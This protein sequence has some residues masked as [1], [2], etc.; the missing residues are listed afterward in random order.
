MSPHG[1][2]ILRHIPSAAAQTTVRRFELELEFAKSF[3][4]AVPHPPEWDR[5]IARAESAYASF[6]PAGGVAALETLLAEMESGLAELGK[7]AKGYT[8]HC[9][10]HGHID[11]NWMWSWPETVATTHDT[12]A[13]VLQ[14]MDLYPEFTYSQ[15]QGSVYALTERYHPQQ[16]EEIGRRVAEGRWEVAAVHWVEGDKNLASGESIARHLLYSRR[17]FEEKFGLGPEAIRIDWEPDTFGHANTIPNI[18]AQAGVA[19]YYCCRPGGGHNHHRV[20]EPRPPV[21]WWQGTDGSRVLVNRETTWYNSYVNIG[22]NIAVP[23]CP[24]VKETGLHHWLNVYGVGNHGGGPTR[25]EI[26]WYRELATWPIYPTVAFSTA[27]RCFDAMAKEIEERRLPIPVLDHELNFEFTG[28]YT[29]QSAIKKANRCGENLCVEAESLE[30]VAVAL[31]APRS[32]EG[33]VREAWINV[34]FNQFH[35]ILPGSG[36]TQTREHATGIFQE[37]AAITG[38]IKRNAVRFIERGIDT[39]SLIPDTIDGSAER[40][41]M[42]ESALPI[43]YGAGAGDGSGVTGLGKPG[44]GGRRFVPFVI[45]NPTPHPRSEIVDLSLFDHPFDAAQLVARDDTGRQVAVLSGPSEHYWGHTKTPVVVPVLDIPPLGYRTIVVME[46]EPNAELPRILGLERDGFETPDL[47]F[48]MDRFTSGVASWHDKRTGQ[49]G[50]GLGSWRFVTERPQGMT[51]WVLGAVQSDVPLESRSFHVHGLWRNQGTDAPMGRGECF[52]V[53]QHCV[54]PGTESTVTLTTLLHALEPRIDVE[55]TV[56]WR[57]IG[58]NERGIPGLV[59]D[60]GPFDAH[61]VVSETP[62]GVVER[63]VDLP[64]E[65]PSQRFV[66]LRGSKGSM[67]VLNDSKYGFSIVDGRLQMRIVRSSFDPDHAPE[68]GQKQVVRYSV[69]FHSEPVRNADLVALGARWNH[70]VLVVPAQLHGGGGATTRGF[71]RSESPGVVVS[72]AKLADKGDGLIVRVVEMEGKSGEA[73]VQFE[74]E[75]LAGRTQAV[76]VDLLERPTGDVAKMERNRVVLAVPAYGV[77]TVKIT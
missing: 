10:G 11:M 50:R 1:K 20:G 23:M 72:V 15:S 9:V 44:A 63:P 61:A 66:H 56:D 71:V 55:A 49:S 16:F 45:V 8:I 39:A 57:E 41:A 46:G 37:T 62:Y 65:F 30:A 28:C 47:A 26:D 27:T 22:E 6:D 2:A 51:A 67:T 73:V 34:L 48:R 58:T 42:G 43:P 25:D 4:S 68:A 21:F 77:R 32:P 14:L 31:G 36:V 40:E 35:D 13:S 69:C 5:A 19:Y 29:S 3:A 17:Y 74:E 59:V 18:L 76:V 24:F 75:M 64:T 60:F 70:P 38:A 52:V 12:F 33:Q 54:V 53:R 7:A